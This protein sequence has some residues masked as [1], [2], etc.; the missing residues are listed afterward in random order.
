MESSDLEQWP[1]LGFC[2]QSHATFTSTMREIYLVDV[3][4]VYSVPRNVPAPCSQL[5]SWLALSSDVFILLQEPTSPTHHT[6]LA[7]ST[8]KRT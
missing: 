3:T 7:L 6:T 5:N 8:R 1:V 2:E 4:G